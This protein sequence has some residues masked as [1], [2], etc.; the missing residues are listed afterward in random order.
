M[1]VVASS[2]LFRAA[3]CLALRTYYAVHQVLVTRSP[4]L[5]I[6]EHINGRILQPSHKQ[7]S[8]L[9]LGPHLANVVISIAATDAMI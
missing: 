1:V 4:L 2:L 9:C 6:S 5:T 7:S 3:T 8:S